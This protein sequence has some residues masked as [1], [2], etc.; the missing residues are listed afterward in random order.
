MPLTRYVVFFDDMA[1]SEWKQCNSI[2]DALDQIMEHIGTFEPN[3]VLSFDAT[4]AKWGL[5]RDV[6]EDVARLWAERIADDT[7]DL[8][9]EAYTLPKFVERF[10][11]AETF[12]EGFKGH[13]MS[14]GA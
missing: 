10:F 9:N 7:D 11:P 14:E 12:L 5:W 2:E 13:Q 1:T 3:C 4:A 8:E 6:S